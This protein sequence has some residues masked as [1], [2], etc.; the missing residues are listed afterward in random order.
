MNP[1]TDAIA[2]SGFTPLSAPHQK[3]IHQWLD[4]YIT[5][6]HPDL[7]REGAVCPFVKPSLRTGSLAT[8][9]RPW[10]GEQHIHDMVKTIQQ[11]I[12]LFTSMPWNAPKP[13]LR[14]L[15]VAMPDLAPND[16]WLID[17]G[18]RLAK[19]DAVSNGIMI[20]QFHPAC[21]A[22]AARNPL[23]PVNQAPLPLI[24]VRN[25]AFHDIIFLHDHAGWFPHYRDRYEHFYAPDTK[26]DPHFRRLFTTAN[27]KTPR[28]AS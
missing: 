3:V 8:V 2:E 1:R 27:E 6:P 25:M 11:A 14:S 13:T 10:T 26:I 16:W 9:E 12:N 18:H 22:P 21:T 17:E 19:D 15:I 7:G 5:T 20:G 23:F 28:G 24:A 4:D